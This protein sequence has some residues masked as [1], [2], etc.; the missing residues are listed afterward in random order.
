MHIMLTEI[1]NMY[2][3]MSIQPIWFLSKLGSNYASSPRCQIQTRVDTIQIKWVSFQY[4][5]I[6][7]DSNDPAFRSNDPAFSN[8]RFNFFIYKQLNR[9]STQGHLIQI[10]ESNARSR[11]L[12]KVRSIFFSVMLLGMIIGVGNTC[13]NISIVI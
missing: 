10:S 2:D 8:R 12:G 5:L 6:H 1:I 9:A 11:K 7:I 4:L 3:P 13:N